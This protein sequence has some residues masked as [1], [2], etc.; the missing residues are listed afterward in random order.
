[1]QFSIPII[2]PRQEYTRLSTRLGLSARLHHLFRFVWSLRYPFG[3][4]NPSTFKMEDD[5]PDQTN[6]KRKPTN[7]STSYSKMTIEQ[8]EERLNVRLGEVPGSLL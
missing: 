5:N 3:H 2:L 4:G 6:K 1:M 7:S 8:A